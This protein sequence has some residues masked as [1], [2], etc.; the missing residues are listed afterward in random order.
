MA[1]FDLASEMAEEIAFEIG[2][3]GNF[4]EPVTLTL[5]L[6]DLEMYIIRYSSWT[7]ISITIQLGSALRL[8]VD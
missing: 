7:S 5:T 8:I 4:G 1:K 3:F 6:G 2:Y